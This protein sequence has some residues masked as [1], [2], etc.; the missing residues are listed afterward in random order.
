MPHG[1]VL[2]ALH[3]LHL[4]LM[5]LCW[6][7]PPLR[8][9]CTC[10]FAD[11]AGRR[12]PLRSPCT[13]SFSERAGRCSPQ[14]ELLE[15]R[16]HGLVLVCYVLEGGL[17]LHLWVSCEA[18]AARSLV[19]SQWVLALLAAQVAAAGSRL[20]AASYSFFL[21]SFCFLWICAGECQGG[22]A[23]PAGHSLL[24]D[25]RV[26]HIRAL[27]FTLSLENHRGSLPRTF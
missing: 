2:A 5:R 19:S 21:A 25:H 16:R 6:Q 13:G 4:L 1:L 24:A 7:M 14:V 23:M 12:P 8:T 17:R 3:V 9:P 22:L 11:C 20:P 27:L 18:A 10:S 26:Q 15:T